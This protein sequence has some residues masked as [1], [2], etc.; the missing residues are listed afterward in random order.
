MIRNGNC[1]TTLYN[2]KPLYSSIYIVQKW[3][4]CDLK[5]YCQD[6]LKCIKEVLWLDYTDYV[7]SNIRI[8]KNNNNRNDN[9]LFLK[10]HGLS[11]VISM[12]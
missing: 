1:A 5:G 9:L 8:N 4:W 2:S 12:G 10:T 3:T 7:F 6:K 11:I